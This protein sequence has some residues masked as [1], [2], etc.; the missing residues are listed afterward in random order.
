MIDMEWPSSYLQDEIESAERT[1]RDR[2]HALKA[3]MGRRGT[4]TPTA[5]GP[6]RPQDQEADADVDG[7]GT[8]RDG[9]TRDGTERQA[10]H[11][12]DGSSGPAST[13]GGGTN[14][15][16]DASVDGAGGGL[17]ELL[18]T[19]IYAALPPDQQMKVGG[20]MN[21]CRWVGWHLL[22][23]TRCNK[24]LASTAGDGLLLGAD[25]FSWVQIA[26]LGCTPEPQGWLSHMGMNG[27]PLA[28]TMTPLACT[29]SPL[30][31]TM[32]CLQAIDPA[33]LLPLH[34]KHPYKAIA[35]QWFTSLR[36]RDRRRLSPHLQVI[37]RLSWPPILQR[38]P[39]PS[40][41]SGQ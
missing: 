7:D 39:L 13:T 12:D 35:L 24:W 38:H 16:S 21:R 41:G 34:P 18:I 32:T 14:P 37:G 28:C 31:C 33:C 8:D 6:S 3:S 30:A 20:L 26:S 17:L 19:P 29:M 11:T 4:S 27:T 15:T 22:A 9:T 40:Q 25:R 36:S 5:A 1:L 2:M 23:C 10:V